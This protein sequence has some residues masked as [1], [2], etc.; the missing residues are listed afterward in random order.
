[1]IKINATTAQFPG[2]SVK[3]VLEKIHSG[4]NE[5]LWGKL[6]NDYIQIC[7]QSSG[8]ITE[9]VAEEI[10]DT[11]PNTSFRLHANSRVLNK[12][13]FYD[14]S[15]FN[16]DTKHY[17]LAL[18][19]RMMRF[20]S[21]IFSIHSGYLDNCNEDQFWDN[22]NRLRDLFSE[23]TNNKVDVAVEGLYPNPKREQHLN[24]WKQYEKLL[25]KDIPYAIDLSHLKIVS[26]YENIWLDD[27]VKELI[28]N[29]NCVEIHVS[30]NDGVYD[31]HFKL[32]KNTIWF[33]LLNNAN[34]N[35]N[36]IIFSEG[37]LVER[38]KSLKEI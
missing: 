35:N 37:C 27:L 17:Y 28:E 24:S 18:A 11:Y 25:N 3:S 6:S 10:R 31:S 33:D 14:F 2:F 20:N 26:T 38:G 36:T 29:P 30:D 4:V 8:V 34:L 7:P 19:D 32:N 21:N 9:S 13:V 5:G 12:H 22:I 16:Q 1:M 23:F 15:T